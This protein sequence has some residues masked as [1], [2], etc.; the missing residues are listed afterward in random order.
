MKILF[1]LILFLSFYANAQVSRNFNKSKKPKHELGAGFAYFRVVNYPGA[2]NST[3]RFI[4]FP[5]FIYRGQ[6]FRADEDGSRVRLIKSKYLELG[7]SGG[8]NFPIKTSQNEV[9]NGMP[10]TG[11]LIGIGPA[12]IYKI[13][14]TDH[15]KLTA[16]LGLRL[17]F[18]DGKFPFFAERGFIIEPNIR[19]WY[20]PSAYSKLTFFTGFSFSVAD[21]KYNGFYYSVDDK[22][23]TQDRS[24]YTAKSGMVDMAYSLGITVDYS[25]KVSLF[26]GGVYSNLTAAANKHSPLLENQHNYAIAFGMTWLFSA[27]S[28]LV[29]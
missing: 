2:K 1:S 10:D 19:Y 23:Q 13:L 16:G 9:R 15:I 14:K 4:P 21:K 29:E 12:L 18:E 27:S 22:Y 17:N 11:A 7:F 20:K 26:I 6:K 28:E 25:S 5:I 8:F 24:A 3:Y